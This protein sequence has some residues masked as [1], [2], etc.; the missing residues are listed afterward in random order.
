MYVPFFTEHFKRSL[1]KL[2][3][4]NNIL[5]KRVQMKVNDICND[6]YHN[7][8]EL[9][10]KFKGKR[11]VYVGKSGYR[12]IYTI[13]KECRMKNYQRFNLCS[14]CEQKGDEAIIF[15]DIQ[16]RNVAYL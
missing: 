3:K 8:V 2:T 4:R 16:P 5:K 1:K 15:W 10:A 14:D 9:T 7:S 13:C 6:P 12:I 11:R